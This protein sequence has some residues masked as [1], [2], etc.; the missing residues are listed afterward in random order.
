MQET[1]ILAQTLVHT[2][3]IRIKTMRKAS[4]ANLFT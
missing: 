3:R 1:D 2:D 4:L